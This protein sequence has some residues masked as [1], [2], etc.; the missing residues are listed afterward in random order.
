MKPAA[1]PR[2][3][4]AIC[5]DPIAGEPARRPLGKDNALV[6][7]CTDCDEAPP[8][9]RCDLRDYEPRPGLTTAEIRDGLSRMAKSLK[10]KRGQQMGASSVVVRDGYQLFRVRVAGPDGKMRDCFEAA[11]DFAG[12]RWASEARHLGST[13]NG[14]HLFERPA[15]AKKQPADVSGAL[16]GLDRYRRKR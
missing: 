8:V 16:A 13:S 9:A 5:T 2:P 6:N 14:W 15:P 12:E 4:C 1:Q 3:F 7:V 11:K 10:V